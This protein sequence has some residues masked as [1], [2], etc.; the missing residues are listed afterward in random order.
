MLGLEQHYPPGQM[1]K[2]QTKTWGIKPDFPP[3]LQQ[4]RRVEGKGDTG[5]IL[6]SLLRRDSFKRNLYA[7]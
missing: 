6:V 3:F 2:Q 1:L 4:Q 7:L 5:Y